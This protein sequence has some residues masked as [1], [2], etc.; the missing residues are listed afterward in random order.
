MTVVKPQGKQD[1]ESRHLWR[2]TDETAAPDRVEHTEVMDII[3]AD[4]RVGADVTVAKAL[5]ANDRLASR[6]VQLM[7]DGFIESPEE[8]ARL[9]AASF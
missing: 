5:K 8:A 1:R 7:G 3:V 6:G 9:N 4:L 2:V